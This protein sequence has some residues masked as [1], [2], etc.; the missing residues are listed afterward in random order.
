MK[1]E[2]QREEYQRLLRWLRARRMEAGLSMRS[3]GA[4]M[5]VPHSWVQKIEQGERRLDLMEYTELCKT[6][7]CDPHEGLH[8]LNTGDTPKHHTKKRA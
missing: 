6:L 3:T 1:K 2:N 8:I 4:L 5:R 7:Q